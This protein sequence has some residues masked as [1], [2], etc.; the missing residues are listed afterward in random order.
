MDII[1]EREDIQRPLRKKAT[2]RNQE[3]LKLKRVVEKEALK[4]ESETVK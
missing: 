4:L 3:Q 2:D 1:N